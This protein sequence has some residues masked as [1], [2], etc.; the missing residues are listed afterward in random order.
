MDNSEGCLRIRAGLYEEGSRRQAVLLVDVGN[1]GDGWLAHW[2]RRTKMTAKRRRTSTVTAI[3][4]APLFP[5]VK[6]W[7]RTVVVFLFAQ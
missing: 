7:G 6:R 2:T 4:I 1:G 5:Q 3:T